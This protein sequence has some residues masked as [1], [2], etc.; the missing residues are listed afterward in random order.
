MI[1]ATGTHAVWRAA[2]G[3]GTLH[4]FHLR[5]QCPCCMT[6]WYLQVVD[7]PE[8]FEIPD[9]RK[10]GL[11][12]FCG[13]CEARRL[14]LFVVPGKGGWS[15]PFLTQG[16]IA[17]AFARLHNDKRTWISAE[18]LGPWYGGAG[19][20]DMRGPLRNDRRD[21][22]LACTTRERDGRRYNVTAMTAEALAASKLDWKT[23]P[24]PV[25]IASTADSW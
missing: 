7:D 25:A 23:P 8:V 11:A 18:G 17:H 14:T 22:F 9:R 6:A 21:V 24:P 4:G 15:A 16:E 10:M 5:I 19:F 20:E 3:A 12:M 1:E 13:A 2:F